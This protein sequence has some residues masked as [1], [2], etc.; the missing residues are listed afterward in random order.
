MPTRLRA[1]LD[2]TLIAAW[3]PS[4]S[5]VVN[6]LNILYRGSAP[7]QS[8]ASIIAF[9][10]SRNRTWIGELGDE[11]NSLSNPTTEEEIR[12]S[13]TPLKALRQYLVI[14]FGFSPRLASQFYARIE[15]AVRLGTTI[16]DRL[17]VPLEVPTEFF[18]DSFPWDSQQLVASLIL[19]VAAPEEYMYDALRF[20]TKAMGGHSRKLQDIKETE[21]ASLRDAFEE[22]KKGAMEKDKTTVLCVE[23]VDLTNAMIV[24]LG[25][26]IAENF[27]SFSQT[28]IMGIGPDGV[29]ILQAGG[30]LGGYTLEEYGMAGHD[31]LRTGNEANRFVT[32]FEKFA[33][34]QVRPLLFVYWM[35]KL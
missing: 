13:S 11:L 19:V 17:D 4:R 32:A 23:L 22:A 26:E 10:T 6:F 29:M 14:L 1:E 12:A 15:N 7:E 5:V 24:E 18:A 28:F 35:I 20:Q 27:C 33:V 8:Q 21:S 30:T 16:V 34:R 31:R 25:L 3:D 9:D 2:D